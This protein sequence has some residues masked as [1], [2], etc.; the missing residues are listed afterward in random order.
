M[1][2]RLLG[3]SL[4]MLALGVAP[5][6]ALDIQGKWGFGVGAGFASSPDFSLIRGRSQSSAWLLNLGL[7]GSNQTGESSSTT[8]GSLPQNQNT[9]SFGVGPGL[10]KLLRPA[11]EFSPYIDV[12]AD[13]R[14]DHNH[15]Y[16]GGTFGF[17]RND[18]T[19]WGTSV[20]L[21]VG[22]E[23]FT[24]W[25]FSLAAHTDVANVGWTWIDLTN[26]TLGNQQEMHT[27]GVYGGLGFSP[28]L[29]LRVYF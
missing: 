20:G 10:R 8:S 12:F 23:Y 17:N 11:A 7:S 3:I 28:K 15:N 4:A 19:I 1:I 9:V 22:G 26:E 29:I 25:H 16:S 5:A 27:N 6:L 18:R 14:Y 2:T 21:A 24:R 13:V